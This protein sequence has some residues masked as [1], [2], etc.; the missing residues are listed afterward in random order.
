M[1]DAATAEGNRQGAWALGLGIVGLVLLMAPIIGAEIVAVVVI[2]LGTAVSVA[3]V[4]LG[5][6]GVLAWSRGHAGTRYTAVL[7]I[8]LGVVGAVF[9]LLAVL[10]LVLGV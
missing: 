9:W 7:G 6:N 10:G 5:I 1:S 4:V 8:V 2:L 3:A